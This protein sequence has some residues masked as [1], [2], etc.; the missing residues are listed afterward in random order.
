MQTAFLNGVFAG[1]FGIATASTAQFISTEGGDSQITLTAAFPGSNGNLIRLSFTTPAGS[2]ISVTVSGNQ[3]DIAVGAGFVGDWT[4]VA[5]AVNAAAPNLVSA[6]AS[7]TGGI[8]G[9]G[10]LTGGSSGQGV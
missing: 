4:D 10:Y 8:V 5:T 3:I 7:G 6:V 1:T 9:A 2:A